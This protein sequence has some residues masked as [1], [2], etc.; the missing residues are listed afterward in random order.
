MREGLTVF[1]KE[2]S[3]ELFCHA[4]TL[5]YFL[6]YEGPPGNEGEGKSILMSLE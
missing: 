4:A 5:D 6:I 3:S 1:G 2:V